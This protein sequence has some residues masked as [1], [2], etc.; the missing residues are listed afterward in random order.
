MHNSANS[1]DRPRVAGQSI[2]IPKVYKQ[3]QSIKVLIRVT[4]FNA[5][6]CFIVRPTRMALLCV[7]TRFLGVT[8]LFL[9][10]YGVI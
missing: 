6:Q 9:L 4:I 2:M 8:I 3:V 10:S 5:S 1:Y 7:K